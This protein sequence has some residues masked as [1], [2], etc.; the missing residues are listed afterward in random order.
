ME[1]KQYAPV[2]IPTLNRYEHFKR[3]LESLERCTGADKTDVYVAL[4]YPP[5]EKYIA[6][7]KEIDKYLTEKEICNN[8]GNLYIIRREHNY[9]VGNTNNNASVLLKEIQ[10]NY[11]YYILSEDD[12]EFSP[13][14]LEYMNACLQ[15]FKDDDRIFKICGYNSVRVEMP[16]MYKN[17]FYI[18]KRFNAWGAGSWTRKN[19]ILET[20]YYNLNA[21]CNIILDD[22]KYNHLKK[23]Y[24]RGIRLIHSMLKLRKLHG[25]AIYE[26]YAHLEDKYFVLPTISKVRNFGNDGTGVHSLILN[27]AVHKQYSEQHIDTSCEFN[28]TNDIFTYEPIEIKMNK[29]V[30]KPS[31]LS[32]CK[33]I[34]KSMVCKFDIWLLRHFGFMPKSK[35]I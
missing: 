17:N 31:F 12:N 7:W 26:I 1:Y 16:E 33:N 25:D 28:F 18:T 8:F 15:R 20:D 19:R 13:C 11:E 23:I 30:V 5:S 6:G 3:C 27:E 10:K 14:F 34:Y 22:I 35:Y 29:Y 32:L 2:I 21:L 9:G 4:D 24:P